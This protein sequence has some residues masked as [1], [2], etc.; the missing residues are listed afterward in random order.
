M[1]I[2]SRNVEQGAV[3]KTT[4]CIIGAGVAGITL[5]LEMDKHGIDTVLL[6]SGGYKPDDATRDLYRGE[7]VGIPYT[8][9]DGS[10]SRFLGGS[11]NCWGGWCRPLDSWDFE[12]RDWVNDSGWPFGLDEL[13]P[14][15]ART[16]ALLKLGENN[17]EPAYWEA[18]IG[19][20]DVKR[21]PLPSGTVRDTISQFSPPVR[22][23]KVYKA[24]LG[25]S[26][27]VRVFLNAN[28]M[29]IGTDSEAKHVSQIDVGTLS[30]RR[31]SVSAKLFILATG[32]I[33]N[34]RL[35]LASN[36]VQAEGLGNGN[37]IV[38]RYFMDHPR[39][40]QGSIKFKK[41]WARN[42]LYDIKYHY[43]NAS[44]SAHGQFISSQFA[45][46]QK[47]L[48][49]ERLLNARVWFYSVFRGENT[50]GAEA[51]I[52]C[53]QA[54]LQKDQP[55]WNFSQDLLTMA[56]HP[57]DTACF[58]LARLLQPRPLITD[59]KFQTIVE[60]EPNRDSRVTLSSQKDA[61]GM[62]RVK[63]DWQ[64]TELVKR[65][66]DRTVTLLAEEMQRTGVADVQ[67][68][69]PLEG[70]PWPAQL[71]GTWHHMGTTRMHDS[72]R[73]GVV[74]RNCQVH[75]MSNLYV[76][77]SSVFPTVGANFPTITIA[78][79]TLRLSEHILKA[80]RGEV[81]P[82]ASVT[83]IGAGAERRVSV[84]EEPMPF[85]ASSLHAPSDLAFM[86]KK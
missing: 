44:V 61:L 12:K 77:G 70:K 41:P 20:D 55:G 69:E 75:G 45:L 35:L 68:D 24:V 79:M 13:R 60:A 85:A 33:E 11:S 51:L 57:V 30:G 46:T 37:D 1:F 25:A 26:S 52:R 16:H 18:A 10:R 67:L 40:M 42:K 9:A 5:A 14:Y 64:L 19:R 76:A 47:V 66:F 48:E 65:T 54:V 7:N 74:D 32:G 8:Y 2:D 23:G 63:V 4:V 22:F 36:K 59:V 86:A 84:S 82:L 73:Q 29:N 56:M 78:A 38:G 21:H 27:H 17:F 43:Q 34:A 50:E 71:E 39:T 80:L 83:S 62:N 6:E 15:Y 53:K 81:A 49:R 72:P 58:G 28:A 3:V 31:F